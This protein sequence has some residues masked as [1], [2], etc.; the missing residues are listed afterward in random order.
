MR[1][2]TTIQARAIRIN[3]LLLLIAETGRYKADKL[4]ADFSIQTGLSRS[5][6]VEYLENLE[7]AGKIK[8]GDE[9]V[10]LAEPGEK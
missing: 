2:R 4:V 5:R 10:E 7:E 1:G 6:V 9:F 3:Q 8:I